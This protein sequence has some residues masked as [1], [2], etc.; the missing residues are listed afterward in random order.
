MDCMV[1]AL[2]QTFTGEYS[3]V[4]RRVCVI[5]IRV[6]CELCEPGTINRL[7][8]VV[9]FSAAALTLLLHCITLQNII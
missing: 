9:M 4:V 7:R 5:I 6:W 8:L 1:G 3:F 2:K